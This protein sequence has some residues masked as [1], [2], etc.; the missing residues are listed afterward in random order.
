MVT[1]LRHRTKDIS[2]SSFDLLAGLIRFNPE[3][4]RIL[5]QTLE[6]LRQKSFS[7][8]QYLLT[9]RVWEANIFVGS[10]LL[11]ADLLNFNLLPMIRTT[12]FQSKFVL[13]LMSYCRSKD[14]QSCV[15]VPSCNTIM[16]KKNKRLLLKDKIAFMINF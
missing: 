5:Y 1:A 10:V 7:R 11:C 12:R 3:A 9:H 14:W 6:R 4:C 15:T 16:V 2:S 13:N 8:L